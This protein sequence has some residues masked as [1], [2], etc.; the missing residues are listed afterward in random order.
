MK[1]SPHLYHGPLGPF[2]EPNQDRLL[3]W[4]ALTKTRG[5]YQRLLVTGWESWDGESL[6][7]NARRIARYAKGYYSSRASLQK[8]LS[9]CGII[10]TTHPYAQPTI[11]VMFPRKRPLKKLKLDQFGFPIQPNPPKVVM[12]RISFHLQGDPVESEAN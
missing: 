12:T 9:S 4:L 11:S 8:K 3:I 1:P 10:V 7:G 5:I 6:L 2:L